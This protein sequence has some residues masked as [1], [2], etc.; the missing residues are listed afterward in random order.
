MSVSR[1]EMLSA[2]PKDSPLF[3]KAVDQA[4]DRIHFEAAPEREKQPR[5]SRKR[6]LGWALAGV[7]LILGALGIAEGVRLGVFDF[8]I[9]R[10]KV[11]PQATEL[12]QSDLAEMTVG[13]TTLRV[14]E[15]VY[16]GQAVRFVMS[17]QN[18]TVSRPLTEEEAYGDGA[19]G[20]ALAADGV[21][22]LYSFDWFTLDGEVF[23]MTGGS[24]GQNAVGTDDGEALIYFE[25]LLTESEGKRIAAPTQDFTL[26][27]PVKAADTLEEQ[28]MLIP[29]RYVAANLLRDV[30]PTAPA[31]FG[32]G[33]DSYT[34]TVIEAK[35][36]PICNT[37]ELRVDVPDTMNAE[38]ALACI[39][40][41]YSIGLV[42]E[43][44][45]VLGDR[46]TSYYGLPAGETDETRHFVIRIEV[47]PLESY[48]DR[49]F[50][51]P[52]GDY[53]AD[54]V[55]ETDMSLA[56]ELNTEGQ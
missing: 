55:Q 50:V 51:A 42:N 5:R 12:T 17:V 38:T 37:V 16:D 11:L 45:Q 29:V 48:P 28:Q 27:V 3:D 23:G 53:G 21:T 19:F 47:T 1:D 26:G 41:W 13:N 34:V 36:S 32:E 7:L 49:M 2:F 33:D 30:T 15:A 24:G 52:T 35:L 54:G 40:P 10:D 18:D 43:Q 20:E 8:L 6:I 14:T 39:R 4:L 44:G 22:A 31:T 56:I 9:G 46:A 25:L